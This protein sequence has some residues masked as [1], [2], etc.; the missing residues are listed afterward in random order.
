MIRSGKV[1][2]GTCKLVDELSLLAHRVN[3][4]FKSVD[5]D[6]YQNLLV[7]REKHLESQVAIKAISSIDPLLV[8]GRE[9][10][11]NV[12]LHEHTDSQDPLRGMAAFSVFGD[13]EGGYL[14]Y[15]LLGIRLHFK[16]G[17]I[18]LLRSRVIPH[19]V[20]HFTGQRISIPHYTHTSCWRALGQEKLVS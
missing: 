7:F 18:N 20:E 5:P 2:M 4:C 10:L 1:W 16:S 9:I 17:D 15:R 6:F 3:A 11:Y 12:R 19:E 14:F 8:E 13:F